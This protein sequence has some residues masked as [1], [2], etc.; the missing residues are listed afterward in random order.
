MKLTIPDEIQFQCQGSGKC[1][2]SHGEYGYVYLSLQDRQRMAKDMQLTTQSFTK[3]YCQKKDGYWAIKDNPNGPDC[4]FLKAKKC[5]VYAGRPTQCRTWPFWPEVMS[6]KS[7]RKDV[8]QF[9]PG[10]GKG[11][12]F[13]REEISSI[14]QEQIDNEKSMF[15]EK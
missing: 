3:Q 8:V 6:P 15:T 1:C 13:R 5:T 11:K 14:L 7:W 9:C 10:I 2:V 12:I 4:I